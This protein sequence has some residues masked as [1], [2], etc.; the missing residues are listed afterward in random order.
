[1]RIQY[2]DQGE[3]I[4]DYLNSISDMVISIQTVKLSNFG[5]KI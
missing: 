5:Q 3:E 4:S 2:R 1:M